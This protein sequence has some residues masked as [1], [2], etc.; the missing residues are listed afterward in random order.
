MRW[1]VILCLIVGVGAGG[2]AL[3]AAQQ[4]K[5]SSADLSRRSVRA[6]AEAKAAF[7]R[8]RAAHKAG[9]TDEAVSSFERA[10]AL[11][12]TSSLY[13]LWLGHA[14]S[15]QLSSAGVLR[16]PFIARRS[17][18]AYQM[19]VK[20]DP[21]SIEAAEGRLDFLLGAPGIVGGGVDKARAEAARIAT[22]DAYRGAMADA[23][24]AEHEKEWPKAEQLYRSLMAQ[25]PDHTAAV[26]ALLTILQNAK[27]F[28][29]AF[30]IVDDRLARLPDESSSLYNLGRLSAVSGQHL[31]RGEA[32]MLRFLA[33]TGA[34]PVR[35]S[36][37]HYRLGMIKE[38]MGDAPAAAT[39]YRAALDLYPRHEP[40]AAALKKIQ[41]R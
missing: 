13:H 4:N 11:D 20:L 16:K 17:G 30:T 32:A 39:E 41:G 35:Q 5:E 21:K 22:L 33:M 31:A 9:K 10:V 25:Y 6:E 23:R 40:A 28:D 19:A 8:G 2:G 3:A 7:E 24:I 36:N 38:K 12:P 18:E 1:A 37:A 27:R 14:Y 15:R 34:D 29:D 26:D